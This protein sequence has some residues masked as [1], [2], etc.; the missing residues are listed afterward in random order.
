MRVWACGLC[1][2]WDQSRRQFVH[3]SQMDYEFQ[4]LRALRWYYPENEA[5]K[6]TREK[7]VSRVIHCIVHMGEN[8]QSSDGVLTL[9]LFCFSSDSSWPSGRLW[10]RVGWIHTTLLSQEGGPTG[11]SLSSWSSENSSSPSSAGRG[12]RGKTTVGRSL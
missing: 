1:F 12:F 8:I 9:L 11:G 7:E 10:L 4:L 2:T 3:H 6:E 5:L